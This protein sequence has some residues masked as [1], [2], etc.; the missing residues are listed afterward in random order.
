M[1]AIL[2]ILLPLLPHIVTG[3]EDLFQL[4]S[5]SGKSKMS[6]V[7]KTVSTLWSE[8][9]SAG[10]IPKGT[11][12]PS[13]DTLIGAIEATLANLKSSGTITTGTGIKTPASAY[14]IQGTISIP[15]T[16]KA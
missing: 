2:A 12:T 7:L 9:E 16:P 8:M 13:S 15:T 1:G 6:A 14:T 11:P 4:I 3:V 10:I 5:K